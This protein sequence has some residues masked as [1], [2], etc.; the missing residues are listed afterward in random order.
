L[1]G[2][3]GS[4]NGQVQWDSATLWIEGHDTW[5][6]GFEVMASPKSRIS[7]QPES[8]PT[9]ITYPY[10]VVTGVNDGDGVGTKLINV[11]VHDT[12]QGLSFWDG[13]QNTEVYGC[14]IYHNGWEGTDRGHGHDIYTQNEFG[15]KSYNDMIVFSG[16]ANGVQAFTKRGYMNDINFDGNIIFD[17]GILSKGGPQRDLLVGG[18]G[19]ARNSKITSNFCYYRYGSNDP[20][21]NLGYYPT[22]GG[23]LNAVVTGNYFSERVGLQTPF[24]GIVMTGNTFF[25]LRPEGFSESQFP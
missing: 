21:L 22:G 8:F 13:C 11:V 14:L 20:S 9:D 2:G 23:S 5:Y 3:D 1:D 16:F 24:D 7:S 18:V 25:N 4:S 15:V 6:W 10:G 17:T 12:A 19:V